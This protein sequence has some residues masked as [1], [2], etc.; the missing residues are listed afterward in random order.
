M[1]NIFYRIFNGLLAIRNKLMGR[2]TISE[3]GLKSGH[4]A[5]D[6]N[7]SPKA[8]ASQQ[9]IELSF[10]AVKMDNL[11][12]SKFIVDKWGD[13]ELRTIAKPNFFIRV[14]NSKPLGEL[15]EL[16]NGNL[17]CV[18]NDSDID[19]ISGVKK[20]SANTLITIVPKKHNEIYYNFF[21]A[22]YE[23][24]DEKNYDE[25][26]AFFKKIL[27]RKPF[28]NNVPS[29]NID[30]YYTDNDEGHPKDVEY[31]GF[32]YNY[33]VGKLKQSEFHDNDSTV[34]YG[35]SFG[36]DAG[37]FYEE[38]YENNKIIGFNRIIFGAT[39]DTGDIDELSV[40]DY[41]FNKTTD[42]KNFDLLRTAVLTEQKLNYSYEIEMLSNAKFWVSKNT[43]YDMAT[44]T[45]KNNSN[46]E[47]VYY[48]YISK[49][50]IDFNK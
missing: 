19:E 47:S 46:N 38:V 21:S 50:F 34:Y 14:Q 18:C 29:D 23:Y 43:Y 33:G 36:L 39:T 41:I 17:I 3:I 27:N 44:G 25:K 37:A 5:K 20:P 28:K 6:D 7:I 16:E 31:F 9:G 45:I 8:P 1:N 10:N 48:C 42:K 11:V 49:H 13:Y 32:G 24:C 15:T 12:P 35:Y 22:E 4:S 26:K 2:V 40:G 30:D